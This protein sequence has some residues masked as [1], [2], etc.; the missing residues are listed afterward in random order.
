MRLEYSEVSLP[1]I[2]R[3]DIKAA[4][5][6]SEKSLGTN[7][8][9]QGLAEHLVKEGELQ[10]KEQTIFL[11]LLREY[12]EKIALMCDNFPCTAVGEI[13]RQRIELERPEIE[14]D[15]TDEGRVRSQ[16]QAERKVTKHEEMERIVS[17][18]TDRILELLR[19]PGPRIM[20]GRVP[21]LSAAVDDALAVSRAL[22]NMDARITEIGR[23]LGLSGDHSIQ[24]SL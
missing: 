18:N 15:R 3:V 13:V 5:E 1:T 16:L 8:S 22:A 12:S 23:A 2:I 20:V 24:K 14:D 11:Q 4:S 10:Y 21:S 19:G 17:G 7:L 6:H 9:F